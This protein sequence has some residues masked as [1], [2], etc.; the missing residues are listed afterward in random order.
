MEGICSQL[1]GWAGDPH[2]RELV[3]DSFPDP[4]L[5]RRS[6]GYAIDDCIAPMLAD[7]NA[8]PDLNALIAGSEGS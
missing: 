8:L 6:C 5:R 1:R 7:P 3:N 4:C 2:I